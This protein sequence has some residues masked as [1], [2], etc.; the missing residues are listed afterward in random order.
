[1]DQT[2]AQFMKLNPVAWSLFSIYF[3]VNIFIIFYYNTND[4]WLKVLFR[5]KHNLQAVIVG[6]LATSL[7]IDPKVALHRLSRC[8]CDD[9]KAK[10]ILMLDELNDNSRNTQ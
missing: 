8:F 9:L 4:S 2:L 6:S 5:R 1:M 3:I 10:P 7:L